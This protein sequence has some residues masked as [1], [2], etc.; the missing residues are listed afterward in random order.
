MGER[1]GTRN[2]FVVAILAAASVAVT[3]SLAHAAPAEITACGQT[4]SRSAVLVQDLDCTGLTE[5]AITVDGGKLDLAG[6]TVVGGTRGVRCARSCRIFSSVPGGTIR[7]S[8]IGIIGRFIIDP[9]LPRIVNLSIT[10]VTIEDTVNE[11]TRTDNGSIKIFDSTIRNTGDLCADAFFRLR[12]ERST[13]EAVSSG[14][15]TGRGPARII[16]S[17][18]TGASAIGISGR[19][20]IFDSFII[21]NPGIGI[22]IPSGRI[23]NTTI[24]GNGET[25]IAHGAF[26]HFKGRGKLGIDDSDVSGNGVGIRLLGAANRLAIRN[27]TVTGNVEEGIAT[28]TLGPFSGANGGE[29]V[30]IRD[31]V[32]SGNGLSGIS[33]SVT[34]DC[35]AIEAS[36]STISGN[37]LDA[38]VCG[39]SETCADISACTPPELKAVACDTSYDTNSGFPGTNWGVC[40]LD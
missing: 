9:G 5:P 37:G 35:E 17:T 28:D 32:V 39:V 24:A 27:T 15:Y 40:A 20:K 26:V 18:I 33:I 8:D 30:R 19:S 1:R 21:D 31:S 14:L 12:M 29:T 2:R 23:R 3:P 25:G 7:G 38:A 11:G 6:H 22:S 10:N 36:D 13:C 16:E 4:V 34:E